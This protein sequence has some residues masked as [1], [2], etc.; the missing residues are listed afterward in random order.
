MKKTASTSACR[1][2]EIGAVLEYDGG[3][4]GVLIDRL[5][6]DMTLESVIRMK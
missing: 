2:N 5:I 4:F 1:A 3:C 6:I